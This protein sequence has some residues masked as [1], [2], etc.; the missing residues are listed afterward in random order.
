MQLTQRQIRRYGIMRTCASHPLYSIR[1]KRWPTLAAMHKHPCQT[2]SSH[3]LKHRQPP[4]ASPHSH[5]PP[6]KLLYAFSNDHRPPPPLQLLRHHLPAI[7]REVVQHLLKE[8][9]DTRPPETEYSM[10][11]RMLKTKLQVASRYVQDQGWREGPLMEE[12][13]W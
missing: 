4:L 3:P 12:Y 8:K 9:R 13:P 10:V 7:C 2:L 11:V 1:F 6:F 5:R